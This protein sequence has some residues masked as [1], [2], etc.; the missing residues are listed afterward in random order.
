MLPR[1]ECVCCLPLWFSILFVIWIFSVILGLPASLRLFGQQT[2]VILLAL[3]PRVGIDAG[4]RCCVRL[5]IF[6][7]QVDAK[8][9]KLRSSCFCR[10]PY[11]QS[12]FP[13]PG[14]FF[15]CKKW[16]FRKTGASWLHSDRSKARFRPKLCSIPSSRRDFPLQGS[17][18][19]GINQTVWRG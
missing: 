3:L 2:L 6:I 9:F 1:L 10:A 12:H 17:L 18:Y 13:I 5:L 16:R 11:P 15:R 8:R 14:S 19:E 7:L 4:P